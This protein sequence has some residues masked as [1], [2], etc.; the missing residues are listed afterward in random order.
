MYSAAALIGNKIY[1]AAVAFYMEDSL[2]LSNG[3]FVSWMKYT[4]STIES[5]VR[6]KGESCVQNDVHWWKSKNKFSLVEH[7]SNFS[8]WFSWWTL[9]TI[10]AIHVMFLVYG[11]LAQTRKI[12]LSEK[13]NLILDTLLIQLGINSRQ[14]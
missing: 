14:F 11:Y 4:V 5:K 6:N 12:S 13:L 9:T 2:W 10:W 1:K 3:I 7:V 8:W